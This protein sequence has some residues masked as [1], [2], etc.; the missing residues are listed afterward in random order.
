MKTVEAARGKWSL[1]LK[2]F[3]LPPVTKG[4]HIQGPCP[5]CGQKNKFRIDDKNGSGSYICVCGS[6]SGWQLLELSQKRPFAELATE[7]DALIGNTPTMEKPKPTKE[8]ALRAKVHAKFIKLPLHNETAAER[9]FLNRHIDPVR[10]GWLRFSEKERDKISAIYAIAT[11]QQGNVCYLHRTLLD[12]DKKANVTNPKLLTK[13]QNQT[14]LDNAQSIAIRLFKVS[15]TLGIAEGIETALSA[16]Q[17]YKCATW[18]TI[19]AGFMRKFKAPA[20]VNHLII[21]AD[22]DRNGTGLAAAF[23]CANKNL[24]TSNDVEKVSIRWLE[25]GDFNDFLKDGGKVLEWI[26]ERKKCA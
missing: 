21:F 3:G 24:L 2:H 16:Y 7:V 17:I 9:Y 22:S 13:L 5:I 14:Y 18:S 1:I 20:G 12:G 8:D 4:K 11:D 10:L 15:S 25:K 26:L 23:D 6:G 19:N